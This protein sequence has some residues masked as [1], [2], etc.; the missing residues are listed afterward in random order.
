MIVPFLRGFGPTRF[1]DASTPRTGQPSALADDARQLLDALGLPR[2]TVVG[3]DWGAR[4][5]YVLAALWPERVERL[6]EGHE[7]LCRE[8]AKSLTTPFSD[9]IAFPKS[10]GC[11][12]VN[13]LCALLQ[14]IPEP[15]IHPVLRLSSHFANLEQMRSVI[16]QESRSRNEL[17]R[18][19]VEWVGNGGISQDKIESDLQTARI[20]YF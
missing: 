15:T 19:S 4:S 2:V 6:S 11:G 7:S 5:A 18:W 17:G 20:R 1:R 13:W 9:D 8:S 16:F 12:G 10:A 14:K 3:H